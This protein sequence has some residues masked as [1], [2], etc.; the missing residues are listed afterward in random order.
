MK[1]K[2]TNKEFFDSIRKPV[3]PPTKIFKSKPEKN[4]FNI[5]DELLTYGEDHE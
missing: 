3:A 5:D 4:Q 2:R 1:D